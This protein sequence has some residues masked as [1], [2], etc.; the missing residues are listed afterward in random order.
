MLVRVLRP[1][2]SLTAIG[3][4]LLAA[5]AAFVI[6]GTEKSHADSVYA[7]TT[8][9]K[10]CNAMD[11]A[12]VDP[13]LAGVASC[14]EDLSL[15]AA[16]DFWTEVDMLSPTTLNFSNITTFAPPG[17]TVNAGGTIPTGA[18]IGGLR[19]LTTLGLINGTCS[20][21][22]TVEF[23][24]FN[25]AL[26]DNAA[27]PRAS[28]NIVWPRFEGSSDRFGGFAAP[29]GV[30]S[31]VHPAGPNP[32]APA[33][34]GTAPGVVPRADGTSIGI[35]GYPIWLLDLFDPDF[36]PGNFD[37]GLG[38]VTG[39]D[40]ATKPLV[41]LAVYGGLTFV[42]GSW[43]PLYFLQFEG[44]TA[45]PAGGALAALGGAAALMNE[46]MGWPSAAILTDP[47]AVAASPST[48][49]DFCT[50]LGIETMLLGTAIG[51]GVRATN[52]SVAGTHFVTQYHA[53]QRDLDQDGHENAIDTCFKDP[54]TDPRVISG[55]DADSDGI[56]DVCDAVGGGAID[57]DG[58][59]FLNRQDNC[60]VL[61]NAANL[62]SEVNT[63]IGSSQADLGPKGDGIGDACDTGVVTVTAGH[64]GSG[65]Y[66][67]TLSPTVSNG[68]YHTLTNVV[69]KCFGG[70]ADL[71]LDG[72][73][74]G[75]G[76]TADSGPG[77]A[78]KHGSW[79]GTHPGAQMDT[80]DDGWS[81]ALETYFG[82]DPVFACPANTTSGNEPVNNWPLDLN[83]S[84]FV[85]TFDVVPFIPAL[86]KFIGEVAAATTGLDFKNDGF[87]NTFDVVPFISALNH[88]CDAPV[89]PAGMG[90]TSWSQQ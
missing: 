43:T 81:D 86:N 70:A 7:P 30:G 71:D 46:N 47:S 5:L 9:A 12:F 6:L 65:S 67:V 88:T 3:A 44:G 40:G 15:G 42:A 84:N 79:S 60:P 53:S 69:A 73:C 89:G 23:V 20:T 31:G 54:S 29:G 55:S 83:D 35:T 14:T 11:P 87:I 22:I 24:L 19:S 64:N 61:T 33:G 45:A 36:T 32:Y 2:I 37:P 48:I 50:P 10:F 77:A 51:G 38:A 72:Y 57:E 18:K 78:V 28:T 21:T 27:D 16:A 49:T 68:R 41:P 34:L 62:G 76:D 85:N 4:L 82:T 56:D 17:S 26:P 63:S 75:A 66:A 80:D 74:A 59:G 90:F 13:A 8:V 39:S 52:P 25:V 58:D 1:A